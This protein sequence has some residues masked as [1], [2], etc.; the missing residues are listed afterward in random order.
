VVGGM[1][2]V[3][4]DSTDLALSEE[5]WA[6]VREDLAKAG[7]LAAEAGVELRTDNIRPAERPRSEAWPYEKMAC[8]IG[9]IFTVIDVHGN[10]DG[11]CTCQ[12]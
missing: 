9:H 1:R 4:F 8:F 5:D 10:V 3:P 2:P 12:N 6:R 7:E 11:C